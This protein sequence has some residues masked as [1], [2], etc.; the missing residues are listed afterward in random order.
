MSMRNCRSRSSSSIRDTNESIFDVLESNRC[1]AAD[2]EKRLSDLQHN[3]RSLPKS[4]ENQNQMGALPDH[5]SC[6]Y[7]L[8]SS[9]KKFK[10]VTTSYEQLFERLQ[11]ELTQLRQV[12]DMELRKKTMD[13]EE[14]LKFS[15]SEY[16][17][18][19]MTLGAEF[20]K[21]EQDYR[22]L[23]TNFVRSLNNAQRVWSKT[24]GEV[25][26]KVR[27]LADGI[28]SR[29]EQDRKHRE[30]YDEIIELV[31]ELSLRNANDSM[32][33]R[34]QDMSYGAD[35][36]EYSPVNRNG[37]RNTIEM[38][39]IEPIEEQDEHDASLKSV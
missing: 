22:E 31:N 8:K 25:E 2:I 19:L 36:V 7:A 35:H 38:S 30:F 24:L 28:L 26:C 1:D 39:S 23:F 14:E 17:K 27:G 18:S 5:E 6:Q 12:K 20:S 10:K 4:K 9:M 3:L 21:K 34:S 11:A 32:I 13:Y 37:N 16:N 15:E 29:F 33:S